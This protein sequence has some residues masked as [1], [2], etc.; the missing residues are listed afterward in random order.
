V[1]EGAA[2]TD[3]GIPS[4]G[5]TKD[6]HDAVVR[7]RRRNYTDGPVSKK[8]VADEPAVAELSVVDIVMDKIERGEL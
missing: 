8:K 3:N 5:I 7:R 6:E 1:A 2:V 4:T